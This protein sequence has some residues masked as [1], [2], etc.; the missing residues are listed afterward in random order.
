MRTLRQREVDTSARKDP[1]QIWLIANHSPCWAQDGAAFSPWLCSLSHMGV[2]PRRRRQ[3][4]LVHP[5]LE[6]NS[7]VTGGTGAILGPKPLADNAELGRAGLAGSRH[8]A[9][10][11]MNL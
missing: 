5:P 10:A 1:S 6:A 3:W 9:P 7:R 8:A 2:I 4:D 11:E